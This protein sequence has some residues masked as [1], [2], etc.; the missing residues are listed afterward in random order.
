MQRCAT[1]HFFKC[2]RI[3][4]LSEI[5]VNLSTCE[6]LFHTK[7]RLQDNVAV[8]VTTKNIKWRTCNNV[9]LMNY[10]D[11]PNDEERT[12]ALSLSLS[13]SLSLFSMV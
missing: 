5:T 6:F 9:I 10:Q 13:L 1:Y 4:H 3:E 8:Q 12:S 11:L 7:A 2:Q